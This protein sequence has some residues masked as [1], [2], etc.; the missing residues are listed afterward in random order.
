MPRL[1][2][3]HR[4]AAGRHIRV[5]PQT[6]RLFVVSYDDGDGIFVF[7]HSV[8]LIQLVLVPDILILIELSFLHCVIVR[9]LLVV[10]VVL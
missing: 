1:E 6:E 2:D 5:C 8:N 7:P 4:G 3:C 9:I 10:R